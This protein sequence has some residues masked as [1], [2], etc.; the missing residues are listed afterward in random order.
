MTKDNNLEQRF[1]D[2]SKTVG[3][4]DKDLQDDFDDMLKTGDTSKFNLNSL[5]SSIMGN[6]NLDQLENDTN[7]SRDTLE[8]LKK[9]NIDIDGE[10]GDE[11]AKIT[12]M[13]KKRIKKLWKK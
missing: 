9:G 7:L 2:E 13:S 4:I 6:A 5:V 8:E 10:F 11:L 3:E 1:K 12:G